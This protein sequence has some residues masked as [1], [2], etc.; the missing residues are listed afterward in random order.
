MLPCLTLSPGRGAEEQGRAAQQA[1]GERGHH[2]QRWQRLLGHGADMG[3]PVPPWEE[4][5]AAG[6][7]PGR[8]DRN[9]GAPQ[10]RL[11]VPH[12]AACGR[13]GWKEG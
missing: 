4:G 1:E 2:P 13:E 7:F 10:H 9:L 8:W 5:D 11:Q 6:D 12:A 3:T